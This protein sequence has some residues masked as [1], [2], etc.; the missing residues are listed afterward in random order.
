MVHVLSDSVVGPCFSLCSLQPAASASSEFH[1]TC[2]IWGPIPELLNQNSHLN[3]IPLVI[4]MPV[5]VENYWARS[6]SLLS[7]TGISAQIGGIGG[8]HHPSPTS[9]KSLSYSI[10]IRIV[11]LLDFELLRTGP[12]ILI[13]IYPFPRVVLHKGGPQKKACWMNNYSNPQTLYSTNHP[14]ISYSSSLLYDL[15]R[16]ICFL[17]NS[18]IWMPHLGHI[19]I[20]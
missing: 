2:K 7:C 12:H 18:G 5:K 1:W 9:W 10:I 6:S 8:S 16:G 3:K 4:H 20:L 13:P 15:W 19:W 17:S 14:S 11:Y